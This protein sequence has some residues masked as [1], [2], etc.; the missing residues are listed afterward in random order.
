MCAILRISDVPG[1]PQ[2]LQEF[3]HDN[4]TFF[5]SWETDPP[6][7]SHHQFDSSIVALHNILRHYSLVGWHCSRLTANEIGLIRKNGMQPPSQDMLCQR[8]DEL[9]NASVISPSMA[10]RLRYENQAD[11]SNRA[12]RIW[13]CFFPPHHAGE[14]GIER[15]FRRWGGEALYNFHESDPETGVV[16]TGVGQ[17]CL[18]EAEVQI[19]GLRENSLAFVIYRRYLVS[20]GCE[21]DHDLDYEDYSTTAIPA[22]SVRRIIVFPES[23]FLGLTECNK[24]RNPLE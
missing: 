12:G 24:W 15:F 4:Y 21:I 9:E 2:E 23:D 5:L 13:F 14:S 18:I 16:L 10:A 1:W 6:P 20:R 7:G 22:T 8:I 3:L 17:P 11:D 19:D